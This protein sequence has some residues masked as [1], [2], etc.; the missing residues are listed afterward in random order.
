MNGSHGN[1]E[2]CVLRGSVSMRSTARNT[3]TLGIDEYKE[4]EE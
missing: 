3:G 4:K 2:E 1:R